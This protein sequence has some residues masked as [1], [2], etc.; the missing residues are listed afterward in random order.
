MILQTIAE[1]SN[2]DFLSFQFSLLWKFVKTVN[3]VKT[4]IS[5][6]TPNRGGV[7]PNRCLQRPLVHFPHDHHHDLTLI[8]RSMIIVAIVMNPGAIRNVTDNAFALRRDPVSRCIVNFCW[9]FIFVATAEAWI[10]PSWL[11]TATKTCF[12]LWLNKSCLCVE[13]LL[14]HQM[15]T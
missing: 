12:F 3:F 15:V 10:I 8:A 11:N 14:Q 7:W 5:Q 2:Y 13:E 9:V 6:L 4:A 1:E